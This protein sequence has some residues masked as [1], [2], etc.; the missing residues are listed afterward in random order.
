MKIYLD[1]PTDFLSNNLINTL[2]NDSQFTKNKDEA[3]CLIV[4]PGCDFLLDE[5]YFRNFSHLKIVG[6]P[7]TGT[8]HID[9][10]YLYNN[11]IKLFSLLDDRASLEEIHASAE[12]TWMHIMN[13]FRKFDQA[14]KN[15]DSWRDNENEKLLRTNELNGKKLGIIGFGRI[16]KKIARYAN[17]FN[18]NV[19]FLDP[20]V[21]FSDLATKVNTIYGLNDC[22]AISINVELNKDTIEF[23]KK[24]VFK[25]FINGLRIIN[26]S[27][28][29]I[30][31]ESYILDLIENRNYFY[32]CDVLQNEQD[33]IQLKESRLFQES[34]NNK[35]IVITPHVAG[36]TYESQTF[37]LKTILNICTGGK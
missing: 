35:N 8:N 25:N 32:A 17:A 12:F 13:S 23:I 21:E 18:M 31:D 9:K 1:C 11:N 29:E 28:G 2:I 19:F 6:T 10:E 7:S 27:R 24:D 22:D 16:G 3:D 36:A 37:A 14:I 4:N 5:K 33:L 34:K 20:N 15:V 30:V 26:T